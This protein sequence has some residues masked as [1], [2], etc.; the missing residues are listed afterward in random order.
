[1]IGLYILL[2]IS[3]TY[4]LQTFTSNS[5]Y[6]GTKLNIN[7][8]KV[9]YE[10]PDIW[11]NLTYI[12][13]FFKII[14][15]IIIIIFI[16]NEF[17]YNTIRQNIINGLSRFDFLLSKL[18]SVLL[19]S[20]F[21]TGFVFILGLILGL[22][23]SSD[24]SINIIFSKTEFILAH[25]I[26]VFAYLTFAVFISILLKKAGLSIALFLLYWFPVEPIISFI[27]PHKV[28]VYLPLKS[29]NNLIQFPFKQYV[30]LPVQ[31]SIAC[32]DIIITIIYAA[33]FICLTYLILKKRDL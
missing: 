7:L 22:L 14:L 29:M 4:I 17:T 6:N 5:T 33:I 18:W 9:L 3:V 2:F 25:F 27:L 31:Q 15:A 12:A 24:T 26:Q 21:S 11:H 23:N 1:M 28:A 20:V 19:L 8:S 13:S 10:F 32:T 16:T 30:N